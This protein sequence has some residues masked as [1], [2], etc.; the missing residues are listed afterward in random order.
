M[1]LPFWF[2][3]Q[4]FSSCSLQK[5][6]CEKTSQIQNIFKKAPI[7]RTF[8]IVVFLKLLWNFC[9]SSGTLKL[10]MCRPCTPGKLFSRTSWS[11]KTKNNLIN[12]KTTELLIYSG[13]ISCPSPLHCVVVT[14][15]Y[16]MLRACVNMS[17]YIY[18][19]YGYKRLNWSPMQIVNHHTWPNK[20]DS[21]ST[22]QA[23]DVK[24]V[25]Y[26]ATFMIF[27]AT[28]L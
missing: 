5:Q 10:K 3:L 17:L 9:L 13:N 18:V 24:L 27:L 25:C 2:C 26:S 11:K 22:R 6:S 7:E 15:L 8:S 4:Q 12:S 14:P 21:D 20:S 28:S 19:F 23:F 16:P 1:K